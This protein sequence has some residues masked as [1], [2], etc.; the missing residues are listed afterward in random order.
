MKRM[1]GVLLLW[2]LLPLGVWADGHDWPATH[3]CTQATIP[4]TTEKAVVAGIECLYKGRVA[5]VSQVTG[6]G[7]TWHYQLK[8]LIPGGRI[9]TIDVRPETGLPLDPS[10]L[11]AVYEALDR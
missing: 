3:P 7:G 4:L 10:E 11:E 6:A 5:K 8:I 9:K 2:W 1:L